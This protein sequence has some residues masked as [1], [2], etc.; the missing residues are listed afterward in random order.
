[1]EH[2]VRAAS[3]HSREEVMQ[4]AVVAKPI[5]SPRFHLQA[6]HFDV[7]FLRQV[8]RYTMAMRK[9]QD[10]CTYSKKSYPAAQP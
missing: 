4:Q 2:F 7:R 10:C 9:H 5:S 8:H 6:A 1:M 3:M